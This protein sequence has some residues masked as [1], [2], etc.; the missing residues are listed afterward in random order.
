[1]VEGVNL[2]EY[3]NVFNQLLDQLHKVDVKV[4]EANNAL[5]LLILLFDFYN[6]LVTSLLLGKIQ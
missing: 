3:L 4:E 6:N 5:L 2:L 1:M